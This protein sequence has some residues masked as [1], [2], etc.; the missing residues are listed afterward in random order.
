MKRGVARKKEGS[1]APAI[2]IGIEVQTT[3]QT[4]EQGMIT[5]MDGIAYR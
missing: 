3:I 1:A 4:V 5:M 2:Q